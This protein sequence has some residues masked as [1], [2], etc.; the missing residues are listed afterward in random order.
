MLVLRLVHETRLT[1]LIC[2]D[3]FTLDR[4]HATT[5]V[6]GVVS[7]EMTMLDQSTTRVTAE[8]VDDLKLSMI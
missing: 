8:E 1:D 6:L 7:C 4:P 2:A 5:S 3:P